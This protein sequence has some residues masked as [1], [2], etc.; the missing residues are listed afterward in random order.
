MQSAL[1][2]GDVMM[3]L[4]MAGLHRDRAADLGGVSSRTFARLMRRY[5]VRAPKANTKLNPEVVRE[6][7]E[8]LPHYTYQQLADAYGVH[9][10]TIGQIARY[11][12][13]YQQ[14]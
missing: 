13:W 3:C 6:I 5:R 12:T 2:K 7:R 11:E 14:R 10:Q 1:Q 4:A 8:K 9:R